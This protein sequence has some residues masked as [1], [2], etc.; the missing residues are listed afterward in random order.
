MQAMSASMA[1]PDDLIFIIS[2]SGSTKD[3][4]YVA[5]IARQAGAKI[6]GITRFLK[7]PLTNYTDVLL[8]C[9]ANEGPLEGGSM[10]VKMSQLY[11]IDVLFHVNYS[12]NT[13]FPPLLSTFSCCFPWNPPDFSYN[14]P[15]TKRQ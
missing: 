5:E 15:G 3:N 13:T 11:I 8:T 9:G 2:Y 7:S 12:T 10:S 14:I 6:V 1:S 4:V